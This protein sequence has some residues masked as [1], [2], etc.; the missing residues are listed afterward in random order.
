M[1]ILVKPDILIQTYDA[2]LAHSVDAW[3]IMAQHV[4]KRLNDFLGNAA[5]YQLPLEQF[6]NNG[7]T[8]DFSCEPQMLGALNV[9]LRGILASTVHDNKLSFG[10]TLFLY[11]QGRKLNTVAGESF[12]DLK[13]Q[14]DG[15]CGQWVSLGWIKDH[16][17][18]Y[19]E[20]DDGE[21]TGA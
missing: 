2:N 12:I 17:Y 11:C 18:E 10:A 5:Q 15:D 4:L 14:C 1:D 7:I 16:Y 8:I 3:V 20:F 9:R 6:V 21:K 19:G 13:Y